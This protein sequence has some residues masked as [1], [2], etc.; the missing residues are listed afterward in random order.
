MDLQLEEKPLIYDYEARR[1]F[2]MTGFV[3]TKVFDNVTRSL[4]SS[5]TNKTII[6]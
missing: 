2:N 4:V 3:K 1:Y 6:R 5:Y